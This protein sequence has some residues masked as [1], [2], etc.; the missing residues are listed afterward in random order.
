MASLR[1]ALQ[2]PREMAPQAKGLLFKFEDQS[3]D[4][5]EPDV[6]AGQIRW[7]TYN[8]STWEVKAAVP[9]RWGGGVN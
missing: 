2:A 9:W 7:P 3:A 5:P 8:L 4:P 6:D 1:R